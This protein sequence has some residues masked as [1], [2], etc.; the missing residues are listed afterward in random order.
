MNAGSSTLLLITDYQNTQHANFVRLMLING[1]KV[2]S[3]IIVFVK[4]ITSNEPSERFYSVPAP[5][6]VKMLVE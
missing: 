5:Q 3:A 6:L 2:S 1:A 4:N